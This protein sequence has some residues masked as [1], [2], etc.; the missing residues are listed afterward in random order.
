MRFK[1]SRLA[2]AAI[3]LIVSLGASACFVHDDGYG[4]GRDYYSP[5]YYSGW[6]G[7][8]YGDDDYYRY[9][10]DDGYGYRNEGHEDHERHEGH[11]DGGHQWHR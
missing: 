4:Y 7:W 1:A 10:H 6:W 9:R 5:G 3:G 11:E 2:I 8:G